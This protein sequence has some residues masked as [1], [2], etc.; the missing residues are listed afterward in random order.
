M[1]RSVQAT[2]DV[3]WEAYERAKEQPGKELRDTLRDTNENASPRPKKAEGRKLRPVMRMRLNQLRGPSRI[4]TGDGGFA[5]RCLSRLAKGPIMSGRSLRYNRHR[6]LS[7]FNPRRAS[8]VILT[9]G[10][11]AVQTPCFAILKIHLSRA[12]IA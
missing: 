1:G 6:R 8:Q 12:T 9:N 2:A 10:E 5:I 3:V 11:S 7:D 4:R